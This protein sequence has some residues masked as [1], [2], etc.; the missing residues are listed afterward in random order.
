[1]SLPKP[2]EKVA[3][4]LLEKTSEAAVSALLNA[5]LGARDPVSAV[6]KATVAALSKQAYRRPDLKKAGK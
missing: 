4:S 3:L 2:I 5:L 6:E 1:M